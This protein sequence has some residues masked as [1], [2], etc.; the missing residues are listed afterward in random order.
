MSEQTDR[1]KK[2]GAHVYRDK[3]GESTDLSGYTG[4]FEAADGWEPS[5]ARRFSDILA[6]GVRKR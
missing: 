1:P 6:K 5:M 4:K 2:T 3:P